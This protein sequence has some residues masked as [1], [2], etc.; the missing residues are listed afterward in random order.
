[1][2]LE[3]LFHSCPDVSPLT[4]LSDLSGLLQQ[5]SAT[6]P[7]VILVSVDGPL[8]WGLINSLRWES[9]D[10]RVVLWLHDIAAEQAYQAVECGVRGI[11]RKSLSPEMILKCVR[12]VA[13]GELWLEKTLTQSFLSGRTVKVSRREN[14]LITLVAQGLKNKEI[15]T[16]M[17]ITEG[18]VK[19]YLSRLFEK[20]GVRDRF[21]LALFGLRSANPADGPTNGAP[22]VK[23]VFIAAGGSA[24]PIRRSTKTRAARLFSARTLD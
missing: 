10:S 22:V 1:M 21:E 12:K 19:V 7:Q 20:V 23:S 11:L 9:P 8:D 18:T 14:E 15:A 4:I 5:V 6:K 24:E 13:E 16:V 3:S 17:D 2:A